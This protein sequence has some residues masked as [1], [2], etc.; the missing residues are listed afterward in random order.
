MCSLS[1]VILCDGDTFSVDETWLKRE[2]R[3]LVGPAVPFG[4][5]L[6]ER[7]REM[8]ASRVAPARLP[9]SESPGRLSNQK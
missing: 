4:T 7:E 9:S 5:T 2:P 6:A 8:V 3:Q 1:A